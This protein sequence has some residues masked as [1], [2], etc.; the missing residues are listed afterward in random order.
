MLNQSKLVQTMLRIAMLHWCNMLQYLSLQ[1]YQSQ[2]LQHALLMNTSKILNTRHTT[3]NFSVNYFHLK[4]I[5]KQ[6]ARKQSYQ[7]D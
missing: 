2:Q 1:W 4:N 7:I 3:L 6:K 5:Q